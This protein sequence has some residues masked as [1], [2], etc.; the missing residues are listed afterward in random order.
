MTENYKVAEQVAAQLGLKLGALV[1]DGIENIS[2]ELDDNSYTINL[3]L[4]DMSAT[5][6]DAEGK[7]MRTYSLAVTATLMHKV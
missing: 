6:M 5:I 3:N 1:D 4:V 2:Y 7:T